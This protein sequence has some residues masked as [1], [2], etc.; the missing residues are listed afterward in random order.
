MLKI[1]ENI[2]VAQV[3]PSL[4]VYFLQYTTAGH[5]AKGHDFGMNRKTLSLKFVGWGVNSTQT[6][7]KHDPDKDY[8]EKC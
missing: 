8:E 4:F 7:S 2:T 1:K 5:F 3:L 6:K